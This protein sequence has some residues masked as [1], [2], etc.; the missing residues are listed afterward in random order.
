MTTIEPSAA[1]EAEREL[2]LT[3]S[4]HAFALALHRRHGMAILVV[5]DAD[6]PYWSDDADPDNAVPSV[7][8]CYAVDGEGRAWDVLGVR[9]VSEIAREL[10]ERHPD[11]ETLDQDL[12][13]GEAAMALYVDGMGE[14]GAD[15]PLHALSEADIAEAMDCAARALAPI[16]HLIATPGPAAAP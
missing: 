12:L 7:L 3:G 11:V 15:R 13:A 14:D 10:L 9:P 4:C 16:E 6:R 8:H 2:Y 1:T 5:G